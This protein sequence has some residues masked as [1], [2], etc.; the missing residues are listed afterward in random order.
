MQE[1]IVQIMDQFGY[2]GIALLIAIE[3]VF[4]PIPSEV[5]LTFGGFMTTYTSLN[6]WLVALFAT[7]GSVV[8]ALVLYGVGRILKPERLEKLLSGKLGRILRLKPEDVDKADKWFRRKG[9]ATVFFCRFIPIVRS[10]I[11][12]PAGMSKMNMGIFLLLTTVG[13]SIWNIVLVMLG[14]FAGAS[15][16]KIAGYFDIYG[17]IALIVI[18]AA[19]LIF[20]FLFYKSRK[21]KNE[22]KE[23][24]KE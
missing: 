10:L 6:T 5:I 2:W 1:W 17:K 3:N 11:S 16:E 23:A 8:G 24:S 20:I 18:A 12:I 4:P 7:V 13:T 22:E 19:F 14:A 21:K 15:W 9:K